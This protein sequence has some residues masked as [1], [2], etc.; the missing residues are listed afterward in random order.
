MRLHIPIGTASQSPPVSEEQSQRASHLSEEMI[1]REGPRQQ[2]GAFNNT[3]NSQGS[4]W[5]PR[6][7]AS[8]T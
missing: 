4:D 2:K 3:T 5:T 6:Q 7:V 1:P 8:L